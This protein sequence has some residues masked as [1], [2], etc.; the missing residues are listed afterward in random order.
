[1]WL[2]NFIDSLCAMLEETGCERLFLFSLEHVW[3]FRNP[4]Q[5]NPASG[6]SIND[7]PTAARGRASSTPNQRQLG[8]KEEPGL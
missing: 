6:S 7:I 5:L 4:V 3:L 2:A 8:C 1:M